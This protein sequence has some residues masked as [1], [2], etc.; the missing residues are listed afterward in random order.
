[1][2]VTFIVYSTPV[3]VY[4]CAFLSIIQ[5]RVNK[6]NNNNNNDESFSESESNS[7]PFVCFGEKKIEE[8]SKC[9]KNRRTVSIVDVDFSLIVDFHVFPAFFCFFVQ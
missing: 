4:I 9:R 3:I 8:K 5:S 7:F 2:C 1:M 6:L